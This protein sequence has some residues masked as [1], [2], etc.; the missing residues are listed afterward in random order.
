M[1]ARRPRTRHPTR[2][3]RARHLRT[4]RFAAVLASLAVLAP[5]TPHVAAAA[6]DT[7]FVVNLS[8]P[9]TD[10][11]NVFSHMAFFNYHQSWAN[12]RIDSKPPLKVRGDYPWVREAYIQYA[13]GGCYKPYTNCRTN[14]DLFVD[15]ANPASGYNFAGLHR[16]VRNV[17]RQGLKPY[18][19]LGG[20]PVK[21]APQPYIDLYFR[22]NIRPPSSYAQW[23][24]YVAAFVQSLVSEFGLAEVRT[25]K[26]SVINEYENRASFETPDRNWLNTQNAYFKLYDYTVGALEEVLGAPYVNVGGHCMCVIP[27]MWDDRNLLN[28]AAQGPNYYTGG[29]RTQLDFIAVSFYEHKLGQPGTLADIEATINNVRDRANQLGLVNLPIAIDE[30]GILF[31]YDD[32]TGKRL[33]Y[34]VTGMQWQ[35]SWTAMLFKKLLDLDVA[36]Y[37][38]LSMSS[39][40]LV[41][42]IPPAHVNVIDLA[43]RM[44]GSKRISSKKSGS[45][46]NGTSQVQSVAA[47]N[48]STKTTYVMVFN[49]NRATG[50]STSETISLQLKRITP[51]T[52]STVN[53]KQ[54]LIDDTHGNYW[55]TWQ[56]IAAACR[57]PDSAYKFSKYSAE[58]PLNISSQ[59]APCWNNYKNSYA[60]AARM[61]PV[62]TTDVSTPGNVV[63]LSLTLAHHGVTVYEITNT[64]VSP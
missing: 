43:S 37:G 38:S 61:T 8:N 63:N 29:N 62:S 41:G 60:A 35:A 17:L 64:A 10:V 28:H 9:S 50:A 6:G 16:V 58:V 34:S 2:H 40:A 11:G 3:L 57:V 44:A 54:W 55:P 53:V 33:M 14:R 12:Q 31:G 48:A 26:W 56:Y 59:Y 25:W 42:G 23:H 7:S 22:I 27:G 13:I 4:V 24:D 5:V 1:R 36:W 51:A 30:G 32:S 47:Y 46:A 49:H 21:F 15:P 19:D 18:F 20:I 52:G 45:P 39:K